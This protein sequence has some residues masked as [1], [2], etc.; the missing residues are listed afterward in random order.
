M[1]Q[2]RESFEQS[3]RP[4]GLNTGCRRTISAFFLYL[5]HF[6]FS[7]CCLSP[8]TCIWLI[9]VLNVC[10]SLDSPSWLELCGEGAP[11]GSSTRCWTLYLSLW[12][13]KC[14]ATVLP[15]FFSSRV[16]FFPIYQQH[17][18]EALQEVLDVL[19]AW[20]FRKATYS[21]NL[22]APVPSGFDQ[23]EYQNFLTV[24]YL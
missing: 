3:G 14:S 22:K 20:F 15:F 6:V 10:Q 18:K 16:I 13:T 9:L 11:L 7:W 2:C 8:S 1:Q 4:S 19:I 23:K 21:Q 5:L 24:L 17:K 12:L